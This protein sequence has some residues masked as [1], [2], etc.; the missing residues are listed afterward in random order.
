MLWAGS[1]IRESILKAS[2]PTVAELI[3][4]IRKDNEVLVQPVDQAS[5]SAATGA[6]GERGDGVM[7]KYAARLKQKL[8]ASLQPE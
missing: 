2:S 1:F 6:A 3:Q 5:T 4:R 7:L 8:K